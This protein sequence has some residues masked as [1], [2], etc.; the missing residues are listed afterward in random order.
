MFTCRS[1]L[2]QLFDAEGPEQ[3]VFTQNATH[4]LNLAIRTLVHPGDRVVISA[5]EHNAVTRTLASIRDAEV[6]VAEAPLFDDVATLEAFRTLIAQRP[7]AVI[8]TCVWARQ[9]R[10]MYLVE[11]GLDI[12]KS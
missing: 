6:L 1:E 3:V 2:A 8:C 5:W 4:A 9:S 12:W 11:T 10:W 7:A